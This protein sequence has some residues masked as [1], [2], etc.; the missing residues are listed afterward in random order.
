[1]LS[2]IVFLPLDMTLRNGHLNTKLTF[3]LRHSG[4]AVGEITLSGMAGRSYAK[5][6][7]ARKIRKA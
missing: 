6:I 4:H 5:V 2:N 3:C 1:M 7:L